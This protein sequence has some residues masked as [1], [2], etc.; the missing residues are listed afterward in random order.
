[1]TNYEFQ[2][3]VEQA[4]QKISTFAYEDLLPEEV[5]IQANSAFYE[6]L[7]TFASFQPRGNRQDDTEARL[8]DISTLVIRNTPLSLVVN[9]SVSV[10][11]LPDNYLYL[12]GIRMTTWYECSQRRQSQIVDGKIYIAKSVVNYNEQTY[13]KGDFIIGT[14]SYTLAKTELVFELSS[15]LVSGRIVRNEEVDKLNDTYYGKTSYRSPITSVSSTGLEIETN[16]FYITGVKIVYIRQPLKINSANPNVDIDLPINGAYKLVAKTV[17][18]ILKV[19]E[20]P[21]QKIQNL[22]TK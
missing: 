2:I 14:V 3:E 21:Q 12:V 18:K 10:A 22:L 9:G 6:W 17:E 13:N 16:N 5:D 11:S 15:K 20:Q 1:M 8:N 4:V 19:T 7:D